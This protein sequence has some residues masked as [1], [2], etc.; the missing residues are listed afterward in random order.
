MTKK[1]ITFDLDGTLMQNP[2]QDGVFPEIDRL[3][4]RFLGSGQRI[5]PELVLEH[6]KRMASGLI[7]DAYNWDD[8]IQD[9]FARKGIPIKINVEE[10][11]RKHSVPPKIFLLEDGVV[12]TLQEL[13][14]KGFSL[15]VVTNGFEKYQKPVMDVLGLT[16]FFE[17]VITPEKVGF[18]KPQLEMVEGLLEGGS[19]IIA[20]VGDR[21]DHDVVLAN[22][23][24]VLSVLLFAN[25]PEVMKHTATS[26]RSEMKECQDWLSEKWGKETNDDTLPNKA[27]PKLVIQSIKEMNRGSLFL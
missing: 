23:L 7:V 15:A 2:F 4:E 27:I 14:E 17:A 21:L 19:E 12:E 24:D 8:I 1:W 3:A 5:F 20:H 16:N 13:K 11:V 22:E 9:V 10:L 26:K 18:G 25:M 6:R